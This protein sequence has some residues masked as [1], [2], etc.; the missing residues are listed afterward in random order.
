MS[1]HRTSNAA[2]G[3]KLRALKEEQGR[4]LNELE[5]AKQDKNVM[6]SRL[7][8]LIETSRL[9][10]EE[11][12][13]LKL[14]MENTP[15]ELKLMIQRQTTLLLEKRNQLVEEES[16]AQS[17]FS[18]RI[19]L[20]ELESVSMTARMHRTTLF[21]EALAPPPGHLL[22]FLYR[23]GLSHGAIAARKRNRRACIVRGNYERCRSRAG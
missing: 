17:M 10:H 11:L 8:K 19:V 23:R 2:L 1:Q 6:H 20:D 21:N 13:R 12:T 9:L 5:D 22:S 18:K 4:L 15:L 3:D 14:R 7:I 16:K